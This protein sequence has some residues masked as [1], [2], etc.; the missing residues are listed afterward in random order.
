MEL[1]IVEMQ[2]TKHDRRNPKFTLICELHKLYSNFGN[3]FNFHSD[4]FCDFKVSNNIEINLYI[5]K[6]YVKR[7]IMTALTCTCLYRLSIKKSQPSYGWKQVPVIT[8]YIWHKM[9][10]CKFNL[11]SLYWWWGNLCNYLFL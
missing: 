9:G 8:L 7:N 4:R 6:S 11:Q 10:I 3:R 5:T 2:K 1:F